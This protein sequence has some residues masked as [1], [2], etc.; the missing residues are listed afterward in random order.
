M[1]VLEGRAESCGV[2]WYEL[3]MYRQVNVRH[4]GGS[5]VCPVVDGDLLLF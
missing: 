2:L 4:A 1:V 5:S 3:K